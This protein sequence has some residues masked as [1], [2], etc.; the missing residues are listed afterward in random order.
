MSSFWSFKLMYLSLY[1]AH[2][3]SLP[4]VQQCANDIIL[5][6]YAVAPANCLRPPSPS[7]HIVVEFLI[8]DVMSDL[9]NYLLLRRLGMSDRC[10]A[11]V[12]SAVHECATALNLTNAFTVN[13]NPSRF[14]CLYQIFVCFNAAVT[15]DAAL[16]LAI[17]SARMCWNYYCLFGYMM[18]T[19]A[20]VPSIVIRDRQWC[21]AWSPLRL[22]L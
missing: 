3:V 8:F 18:L 5:L 21:D 15:S 14:V 17:S 4:S 7:R 6:S 16:N 20:S 19:R 10:T 13:A 1:S 9:Y 12:P 11:A 2:A 22:I